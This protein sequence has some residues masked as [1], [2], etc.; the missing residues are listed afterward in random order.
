MNDSLIS[1]IAVDLSNNNSIQRTQHTIKYRQSSCLRTH[2][3]LVLGVM[4]PVG[5]LLGVGEGL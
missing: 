1:N 4:E 2:V 5:V 3:G